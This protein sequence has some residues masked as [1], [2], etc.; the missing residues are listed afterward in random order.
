MS[1]MIRQNSIGQTNIRLFIAKVIL[2]SIAHFLQGLEKARI[3]V[4]VY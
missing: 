4:L 1:Q 3:I 2:Q